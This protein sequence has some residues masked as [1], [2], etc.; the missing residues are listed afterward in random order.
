MRAIV[1]GSG[2]F[3][4]S[5]AASA[6]TDGSYAIAISADQNIGAVEAVDRFRFIRE[7]ARKR[8]LRS[9]IRRWR[10]TRVMAEIAAKTVVTVP[11]PFT[12]R[13]RRSRSFRR[14]ATGRGRAVRDA[15]PRARA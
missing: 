6:A 4:W 7:P 13:R 15:R 10:T 3:T 8:R 5:F 1:K 2:T 9:V 11:D 12:K 14:A